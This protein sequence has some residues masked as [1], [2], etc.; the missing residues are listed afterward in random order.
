MVLLPKVAEA[1]VQ[2]RGLYAILQ[3]VR[4]AIAVRAPGHASRGYA[5]V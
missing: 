3:I 5:C 4:Q 2:R 1:L